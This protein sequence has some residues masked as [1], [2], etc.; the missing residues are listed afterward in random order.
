[1][2]SRK[3][4]DDCSSGAAYTAGEG[5]LHDGMKVARQVVGVWGC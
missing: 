4:V 2:I 3:E 1:M 5:A